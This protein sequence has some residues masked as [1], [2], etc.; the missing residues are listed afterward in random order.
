[1]NLRKL[2]IVLLTS[3]LGFLLFPSPIK[4]AGTFN[5][6]WDLNTTKCIIGSNTCSK[7]FVPEPNLCLN[8]SPADCNNTRGKPC[9][10]IRTKATCPPGST[11]IQLRA[12]GYDYGKPICC[13][14]SVYNLYSN[15]LK[16][17]I[18][19]AYKACEKSNPVNFQCSP[20]YEPEMGT[21]NCILQGTRVHIC[22]MLPANQQARCF[23][24][25]GRP[26]EP[27]KNQIYTAL[28]C[29]KTKPSD[30]IS[31]ILTA[32]IGLGG[33]IAFLL[34]LFGAF[35]VMMSGGDP[36]KLNSG[37]EI[38]G[39]AIAGLLMILFSVVLFKVIGYDILRIPGITLV[40]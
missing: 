37:K 6:V 39:S 8:L 11:E 4:A 28:G 13:N 38:L 7:N 16:Y 1:M 21:N 23:D 36:E 24:C 25:V 33:G 9:L 18:R 14:N 35:Q 30:F 27:N 34:M 17:T 40:K 3:S 10:A 29:I 5:C 31:W 32:A 2:F 26:G 22:E 12:A 15:R 19:D 20:P